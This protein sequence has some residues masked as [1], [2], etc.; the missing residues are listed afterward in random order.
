MATGAGDGAGGD[1]DLEVVLAK[2]T[3]LDLALWH[4]GEHLNLALSE[5][6]TNRPV[7]P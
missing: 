3:L 6:G 7:L 1:V 2:H 5:L 4:L